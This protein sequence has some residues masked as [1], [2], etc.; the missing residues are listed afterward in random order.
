MIALRPW[1]KE[2]PEFRRNYLEFVGE[3]HMGTNSSRGWDWEA[4][5]AA[6]DFQPTQVVLEIGC[7]ASYFL[8]YVSQFVKQAYGIDDI[9]AG[10]FSY[11][12]KPW[13]KSL[14]DFSAY[15]SGKVHVI[16]QN[17]RELPFP[18]QFFD[19]VY[20][21][22]ALE[23]FMGTDDVACVGEVSRTLKV[24][25]AF[26]GTVDFNPV[27]EYPFEGNRLCR[28]YTYRSLLDRIIVPSGMKLK[29]EDAVKDMPIPETFPPLAGTLFF[30]L[31]KEA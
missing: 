30:H 25:G 29:G 19:V 26:L 5:M 17:A 11:V 4:V 14:H 3:E 31:V 21:I 22:S 28:T 16:D 6:A 2:N 8:F 20:T 13:L 24:G 7:A 27:T 15:R 9:D 12:T 18:D 23:H 10:G 1:F